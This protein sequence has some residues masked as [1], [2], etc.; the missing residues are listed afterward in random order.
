M[1]VAH[2]VFSTRQSMETSGSSNRL[3]RARAPQGFH[4]TPHINRRHSAALTT[5][6]IRSSPLAGPAMSKED[7]AE[8]TMEKVKVPPRITASAPA[9]RS[10]SFSSLHSLD[11]SAEISSSS[12]SASHSR[13]ESKVSFLLPTIRPSLSP[14][15]DDPTSLGV[16]GT[17]KRPEKRRSISQPTP[18]LNVFYTA[19]E[20]HGP[21]ETRSHTGSAATPLSTRPRSSP[22]ESGESW[23]TSAPYDVTPRFSRLGLAAPGVVMPE[24]K[25]IRRFKSIDSGSVRSVASL[26]SLSSSVSSRAQSLRRPSTPKIVF[27]S[28]PL[29]RTKVDEIPEL[30]KKGEQ[31]HKR[32]E[33]PGR[34]TGESP[35]DGGKGTLPSQ[36][37]RVGTIKKLWRKLSRKS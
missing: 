24:R 5:R 27:I 10:P 29:E 35:Q 21:E 4:S 11:F 34:K 12:S 32:I 9:S 3:S 37:E 17:P 28:P 30:G 14:N 6:P 25:G 15:P 1:F 26:P 18:I 2:L 33:T 36:V 22:R 16:D 7:E 23:L 13:R 20:D 31:L 8:G 19:N